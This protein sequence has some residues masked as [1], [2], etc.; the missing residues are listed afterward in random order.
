MCIAQFPFETASVKLIGQLEWGKKTDR[1]ANNSKEQTDLN[2][3]SF[4]SLIEKLK[5]KYIIKGQNMQVTKNN[6]Q[7]HQCEQLNPK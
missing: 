2:N 6:N 5:N 4:N 7:K 3:L 1:E